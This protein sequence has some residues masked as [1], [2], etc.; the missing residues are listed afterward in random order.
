M[1]RVLI[2]SGGTKVPMDPVRAITNMSTGRFG[3]AIARELLLAGHEVHFLRAK[4]SQSP[5]SVTF[6]FGNIRPD[7][8]DDPFIPATREL[9]EVYDFA[10]KHER[11]YNEYVYSTAVDYTGLLK[12]NCQSLRP[13]VVILA[14]AVSDYYVE[15]PSAS[16]I[17]SDAELTI[18]LKRAEKVISHVKEWCPRAFLVGFKLTVGATETEMRE[19]AEKSIADN[20]CDMVV[21]NDLA[22]IKASGRHD[23]MLLLRTGHVTEGLVKSTRVAPE[24]STLT[25]A[26]AIVSVLQDCLKRVL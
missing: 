4:D 12:L 1:L 11:R 6:D 14:A 24:D 23:V 5:M 21:A 25:P 18:E 10:V 16:K 26:K 19:A 20:Q 3:S 7:T 15:A 8:L 17:K 9:L 13:D 2:T 22:A